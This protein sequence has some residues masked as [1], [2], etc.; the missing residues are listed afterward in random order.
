LPFLFS[1]LTISF[2][3]FNVYKHLT[4]LPEQVKAVHEAWVQANTLSNAQK[5]AKQQALEMEQRSE[6]VNIDRDLTDVHK[7]FEEK[8]QGL[9]LLDMDFEP[10]TD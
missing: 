8:G 3:A 9:H 10:V 1:F 2:S 5:Q 4:L 7:L 6:V